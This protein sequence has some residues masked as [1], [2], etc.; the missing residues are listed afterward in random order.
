MKETIMKQYLWPFVAV[1]ALAACDGPAV[2]GAPTPDEV[3]TGGGVCDEAAKIYCLDEA[4][5]FVYDAKTDTI[6][7]NNLPFDL[8]GQYSAVAGMTIN[9]YQVYRNDAGARTYYAIYVPGKNDVTAASVV[10][11][12]DWLDYGYSGTMYRGTGEV[13]LPTNAQ[14]SYAGTYQ[15]IRVYKD[16]GVADLTTG[17]I[18]MVVDFE[19]FDNTGAI[20]TSIGNRVAYNFDGSVRGALPGLAVVDTYHEDGVIKDTTAYEVNADGS[21]GSTGTLSG[22]FGGTNGDQIAGVL[23]LSG[24]DALSASGTNVQETAAFVIDQVSLI[25]P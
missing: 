14:A 13:N 24:Q 5:K 7:I 2:V 21:T 1:A 17:D 11:T 15:G 25:V 6:S 20:T 9:G 12:G 8:A 16:G 10:A 23:V 4:N 19:D 3:I 22:I 18:N